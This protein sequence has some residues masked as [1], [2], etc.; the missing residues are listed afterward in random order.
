MATF[1]Q[2]GFCSLDEYSRHI[3]ERVLPNEI[4]VQSDF[5]LMVMLKNGMP[6]QEGL[7]IMLKSETLAAKVEETE[8]WS[9]RF[10]LLDLDM[11][12]SSKS[13]RI[14]FY[15]DG[16]VVTDPKYA[17]QNVDVAEGYLKK[18]D[19]E[20]GDEFKHLVNSIGFARASNG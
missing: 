5:V 7:K 12:I 2:S 6:S 4:V 8:V 10:S 11:N 3:D 19:D 20:F 13:K 18:Y 16:M 9:V 17:K 1:E 15:S 14:S